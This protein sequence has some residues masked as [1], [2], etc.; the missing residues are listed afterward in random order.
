MRI[1]YLARDQIE[2]PPS[3][4]LTGEAGQCWFDADGLIETSHDIQ[5]SANTTHAL[6]GHGVVNDLNRLPI[7]GE[8]GSHGPALLPA[9]TLD[10]VLTL[11]YEADRKTYGDTWEFVVRQVEVPEEIEYRIEIDNRE[12]QHTL[13][14][15]QFLVSTSSREGRG[16]WFQI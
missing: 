2:S 16:V 5:L 11:L 15:L 7:E 10:A 13:S 6:L 4:Y 12:Y 9:P 14:R 8:I 3:P 1:E